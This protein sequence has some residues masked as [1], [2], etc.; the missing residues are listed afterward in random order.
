MDQN[1][2]IKSRAAI[3][4]WLFSGCFLIFAMV[5][6]G[7]ITRL[8]GSGLSITKWDIVTGTLPPLSGEKWEHEFQLYRQT[9]QYLQINS[10]FEL[11]DFKQIYW[12]EYIHRL[13]GRLIGVVFLIP[14][15]WFL[16]TR[17]LNRP[18]IYKCLLLFFM[19]A[20]QG[21]IG[22]YMVKSGL[23]DIPGV[24]HLRLA[25]HLVT[26]FITFGLTFLFGLQLIHTERINLSGWKKKLLSFSVFIFAIVTLQIIYGAFVAG[27]K[28]GYVY[29]TWPMMGDTLIADSFYYALGQNGWRALVHDISGVQVMHRYIAYL[30][31]FAIL[32][33]AW[34][35][36]NKNKK[37]DNKLSFSQMQAINLIVIVVTLQFLLGILTLVYSVP[38]ALGVLHQ[39]GAFFLFSSVIYLL[40][41][42]TRA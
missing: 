3:I 26:A 30:V 15:L 17:Q 6:V 28:A 36:K 23:V 42:L 11:N 25:L 10:H 16:F 5:I 38:V 8:T 34:F 27:L 21:F 13:L 12:W 1:S 31:F 39:V 18:L 14:F 33:F 40:H 37:S 29:N 35:A 9:P 2:E 24:S 32:A 41:R 7:G 22:W 20:L 19:G 4:A